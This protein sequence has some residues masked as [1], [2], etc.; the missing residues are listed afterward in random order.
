MNRQKMFERLSILEQRKEKLE[1]ERE[2][3]SELRELSDNYFDM[4]N[5]EVM[6]LR[7]KII[8]GARKN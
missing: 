1:K 5:H 3:L 8:K 2:R 6:A 7:K 4:L